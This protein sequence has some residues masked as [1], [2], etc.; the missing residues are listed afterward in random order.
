RFATTL[1]L[2]VIA[3]GLAFLAADDQGF[4]GFRGEL[5]PLVVFGMTLSIAFHRELALLFTAAVAL[6]VVVTTGQDLS[7]FMILNAAAASAI[8][9]VGSIRNRRKLI[10]VGLAVALVAF[11]TTLGVGTLDSQPLASTWPQAVR[12]AVL[13]VFAGLLMLGLLPFIE[14][15]F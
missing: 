8:L 10:Y 13:S 5:V 2:I 1:A 3:V 15:L 7:E 4:Q 14:S 6:V 12:Y 11:L 9:L